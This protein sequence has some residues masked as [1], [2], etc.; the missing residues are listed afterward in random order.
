VRLH[1]TY[2]GIDARTYTSPR[3]PPMTAGGD[4]RRHSRI[5]SWTPTLQS[6]SSR[7]AVFE[8]NPVTPA[9]C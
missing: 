9:K 7:A 6:S 8:G 4:K 1:L 5:L 2:A 3:L